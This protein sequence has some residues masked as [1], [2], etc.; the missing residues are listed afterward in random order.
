MASSSTQSNF[1]S[2]LVGYPRREGAATPPRALVAASVFLMAIIQFGVFVVGARGNVGGAVFSQNGA[3]PYVKNWARSSNPRT[4]PQTAQRAAV[5]SMPSLWRALTDPQKTD[6]DDF[7][8]LPAQE[9]TNELGQTFFLNGFQWFSIINV[10]LL[11]I[12]RATRIAP[13]T[14][15]RPSAPTF[16]A[17]QLPFLPQQQAIVTYPAAEFDP[18]FD[19]VLF[20]AVAIST[21]RTVAPNTFL[22]LKQT[23][24]PGDTETAFLNQYLER[25]ALAGATVKGFARLHR[26]T[27]D[28]LRSA[29][30][31]ASFISTDAA[32][33]T[34]AAFSYDGATDWASRGADLTGVTDTRTATISFWFRIDGGAGTVRDVLASSGTIYTLAINA[35][36]QI[37]LSIRFPPGPVVFALLST[38]TFP[39]DGTWHHAVMS[40]DTSIP[41]GQI[42]VDG[43]NES[44]TIT[45][46]V[47]NAIV[48][49][50][51]PDHFLGQ[52][53][54]G[55]LFWTGCLSQLYFNIDAALDLDDPANVRLFIDDQLQPV[56]LGPSGE[57][58]TELQP[59]VCFPDGDA[60]NNIGSGGNYTN[61]TALGACAD[62]P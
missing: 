60:S 34:T 2:A 32:P 35:A 17:L 8:L 21:G 50:S 5:A 57:F 52:D 30:S 33:F 55:S 9:R 4:P 18:D 49:W 37:Q 19:L 12:A 43:I 16:T 26:Q 7:A 15:S 11:N 31:T 41:R 48:D 47:K 46:A 42:V 20:I 51:R 1:G 27:T 3:G 45:P 56:D 6:W 36:D 62:I 29:P 25:Y 59:I 58:P 28:G 10:R 23:Q 39:A 24:L 61:N 13:P 40:F 14:Q 22:L 44:V 38:S 53:G 54:I